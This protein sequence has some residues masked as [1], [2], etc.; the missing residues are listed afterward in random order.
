MVQVVHAT[1]PVS[2]A[3]V[4]QTEWAEAHAVTDLLIADVTGLQGELAGKSATD[5]THAGV[6]EPADATILKDADIGSSVAAFSHTHAYLADAPADGNEYVRKDGAWVIEADGGG[7]G[8]TQ[9]QVMARGL[10]A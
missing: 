2:P 7:G 6:Y 4:G 5:H 10:G 1:I 3:Q 8:L 9:P